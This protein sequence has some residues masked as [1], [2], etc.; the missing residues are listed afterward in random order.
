MVTCYSKLELIWLNY[1]NYSKITDLFQIRKTFH[2]FFG[3][4]VYSGE[5]QNRWSVGDIFQLG[6]HSSP[7]AREHLNLCQI[8]LEMQLRKV[9]R[10]TMLSENIYWAEN[11]VIYSVTESIFCQSCRIC[12]NPIKII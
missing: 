8:N 10:R 12:L 7:L 1:I 2:H 3:H 4:P 9:S 6:E 5:Y 11:H